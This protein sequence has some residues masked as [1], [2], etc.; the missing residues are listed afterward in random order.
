VGDRRGVI[1]KVVW[2]VFDSLSLTHFRS[3]AIDI[4]KDSTGFVFDALKEKKDIEE[5]I[6]PSQ[7]VKIELALDRL[8]D[9]N[10]SS[11][12][13]SVRFFHAFMSMN[14]PVKPSKKVLPHLCTLWNRIKNGS[15]T[16]TQ[17]C[18]SGWF[19]LPTPARVPSAYVC[20]RLF[21]L[22]FFQILRIASVFQVTETDS[23]DSWRK[24]TNK[25]QG[26][27]REGV[28]HL[29]INVIMPLI[30]VINETNQLNHSIAVSSLLTMPN[31]NQGEVSFMN[32]ETPRRSL[33]FVRQTSVPWSVKVIPK[34]RQSLMKTG[35]T[36]K[37]IY[38]NRASGS[39]EHLIKKRLARC[40]VP[41]GVTLS[42]AYG[43]KKYSVCRLCGRQTSNF[44]LGCHMYFCN[45]VYSTNTTDTFHLYKV[46][47][48]KDK[49]R[50][51]VHKTVRA[52]QVKRKQETSEIDVYKTFHASCYAISHQRFF[53]SGCC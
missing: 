30:D 43:K 41:M 47:I 9:I 25:S 3:C 52:G 45:K 49:V 29:S 26:S 31:P 20:H 40:T 21:F 48:G 6:S 8:G 12:L 14:L 51:T 10:M 19:P 24:R 4:L 27:F 39:N 2:V 33:R 1:L 35:F 37:K 11:F 38:K 5:F 15:D 28:F 46:H 22:S 17:V 42:N 7:R 32:G 23:L 44:C 13:H 53:D 16:A 34:L 36:P 50:G 18:R